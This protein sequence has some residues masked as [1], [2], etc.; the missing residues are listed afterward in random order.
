MELGL[1]MIVFGIQL[2]KLI[3]LKL[4]GAILQLMEFSTLALKILSHI[5]HKLLCCS[6]QLFME[7]LNLKC[8]HR[9]WSLDL[10]LSLL[11][12]QH[13]KDLLEWISTQIKC[14]HMAANQ[15]LLK[16]ILESFHNG[17]T[18]RWHCRN[19]RGRL[20]I[21]STKVHS[22]QVLTKFLLSQFGHQLMSLT[23]LSEHSSKTLLA[24]YLSCLFN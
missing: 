8:L 14:T 21:M 20:Q 7:I 5:M 2:V 24:N 12:C 22:Q 6:L 19:R 9:Q 4:I 1:T 17:G 3:L 10:I 15:Q 18:S 13:K 16:L 11:S 23:L